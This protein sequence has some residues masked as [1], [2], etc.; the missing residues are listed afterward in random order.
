MAEDELTG[1][2]LRAV[3][4]VSISVQHLTL[5][6]DLAPSGIGRLAAVFKSKKEC[7]LAAPL[8]K[9]ILNN[10]SAQISSGSL[11]AIL[12]ASGSGKTSLL[13]TMSQRMSGSRLKKTGDI[14]YN[15]NDK[16]PSI[17]SAYVMQK[18]VLLPTLTVRETLKYSA[19]LRLPPP[20]TPEEREA[21]VEEILLEL[22]LKE[23]ADTRIGNNER[24]GCSGGEKR[25]TSL[26]VQL[27]ANPSVLFLDEVTTGLDATSAL[28]LIQTLKDLAR[29]G[30]TIIVTLHQP[31]SEIWGLFDHLILL[32]GGSPVY[33]GPTDS[34]LSYFEKLGHTLA[35]FVNPAEYLIDLAAID[36][37]SKELEEQSLA[38]VQRLV[39]SW[40]VSPLGTREKEAVNPEAHN[41]ISSVIGRSSFSRQLRVQTARTLK[42]TWRDPLGMSGSLIEA[43][44]MGVITGWVF[45]NQDESLTGIR[46]RE[47]SLYTAAAFQGFLILIFE[48]YRLTLDVPIFDRE[49]AE[50][51]VGVSSFLLSRRLARLLI[52]DV[53]VPLI[54]SA[55]FYFLAGFRHLASQFFTFFAL[56]L[57]S[58]YLSVTF[59]ML[60]VAFSRNFAGASLI[61]N[62]NFTVQ[63]LCSKYPDKRFG[64]GKITGCLGGYF[65]Q[66]NQIPVYV[67]WLKVSFL[68]VNFCSARIS[69]TDYFL[70][71]CLCLV[72]QRSLV[73][74]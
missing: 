11:T 60:C 6:I 24:K 9:T 25:R 13:N 22:G 42:T 68:H 59:A 45:L 19:E 50:G 57:L 26:G 67:R 69:A 34:C 10:V 32:T 5:E 52:E 64:N 47:G 21:I 18:D 1:L 17:R 8:S 72:C 63:T 44:F 23:C 46:S 29:K 31:R 30:R 62:L 66:S 71:C 20:V 49:H 41:I 14:L 39:E 2:S 56:L 65:V 54:F 28:Q 16:L 51:V 43:I 53:P 35:P 38:R 61:A 3:A 33:S 73:R 12:G 74:Q 55:A 4:P 48:T 58:Q 7:G 37:R 70:V 40:K 27:L 36:T 15:G